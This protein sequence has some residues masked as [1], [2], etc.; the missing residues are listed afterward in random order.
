MS[1]ARWS[2]VVPAR[3]WPR[4]DAA[5]GALGD[6]LPEVITGSRPI[7]EVHR[8][9]LALFVVFE[10][11]ALRVSGSL[12]RR[13]PSERALSFA[14]QQTV[15]EA[16]HREIFCRRFD[17]S[18]AA[19]GLPAG[20]TRAILIP[21]LL[22]FI[23]LCYEVADSGRFAEGLTLMNLVL[24]GMAY[25]LYQYEVRYWRPLDPYLAGLI[26]SA[27]ADESRHV[28]LGAALVREVLDGDPA[29]KARVERTLREARATM[30]EVFAYYVRKFVGLFDAVA[31]RHGALFAGAE[32]APGRRIADTPYQDQ[33]AII[34]HSIDT[35]HARLLARAGLGED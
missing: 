13:A 35:E 34:Q 1:V 17:V 8:L 14:A 21:P 5:L 9:D 7:A 32:V 15:D 18:C 12:T 11:A 29:G 26:E 22:R 25:P 31:R 2:A 33:I 28:A 3:Q 4:E 16:R 20:D 30:R 27:F 23:D 6:A 10:E 24:E 19:A